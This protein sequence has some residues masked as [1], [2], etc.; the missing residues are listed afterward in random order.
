MFYLVGKDKCIKHKKLSTTGTIN[1]VNFLGTTSLFLSTRSLKIRFVKSMPS[2][3]FF[4]DIR[5]LLLLT[6]FT[7]ML[8]FS[9]RF[10]VYHDFNLKKTTHPT[11]SVCEMA[12]FYVAILSTLT[13]TNWQTILSVKWEPTRCLALRTIIS[14]RKLFRQ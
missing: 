14:N 7:N 12:S 3:V 4:F 11:T 10:S 2:I 1:T 9:F 13:K 5:K 8:I 6:L